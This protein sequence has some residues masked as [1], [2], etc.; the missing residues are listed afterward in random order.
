MTSRDKSKPADLDALT[1]ELTDLTAARNALDKLP[2]GVAERGNLEGGYWDSRR[3]RALA[4]DRAL[5][6]VGLDW[7]VSL[8]PAVRPKALSEQY[9]RI[10][11]TVAEIWSDAT[12][13]TVMLDRLLHDDRGG[14]RKGF[15]EDVRKDLAILLRYLKLLQTRDQL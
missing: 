15:P 5:T 2:P 9:P 1:F 10:A 14:T 3:R 8:P 12:R 7:V 4:S 11:N 6:G 13:A